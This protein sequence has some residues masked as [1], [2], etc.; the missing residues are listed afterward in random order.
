MWEINV[1]SKNQYRIKTEIVEKKS[2]TVIDENI[3]YYHLQGLFLILPPSI[4]LII[5]VV[6]FIRKRRR[7][8]IKCMYICIYKTCM[9]WCIF[10]SMQH[11]AIECV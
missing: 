4:V 5:A 8:N 9:K 1:N 11:V 2:S 7:S 3:T 6:S 10:A